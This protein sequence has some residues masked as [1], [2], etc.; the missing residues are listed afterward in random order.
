MTVDERAAYAALA[1]ARVVVV[2]PPSSEPLVADDVVLHLN[3]SGSDYDEDQLSAFIK[4]ARQQVESDTGR[5]LIRQTVDVYYDGFPCSSDL[6]LPKP[7]LVSVTSVTTYDEDNVSAV[8]SSSDYLVDTA[9]VPA[10]LAL[11]STAS[12]PTS[13][14]RVNAV[15]VRAVCG[16]GAGA[17]DV[18]EPLREAMRLLIGAMHEH[19]EQV[20]VSQ[21]AGQ[22]LEIPFGYQQLIAPYRLWLA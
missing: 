8:M 18:P 3:L 14:R 6:Y 12:W 16:Y 5:A 1:S 20:I 4:A 10:R 22:F 17:T 21:F 9:S 15:I 2:T 13:L 19:R 7:P 11:N